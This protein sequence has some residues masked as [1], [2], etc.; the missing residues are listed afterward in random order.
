MS[1]AGWVL[2]SVLLA[3]LGW[4]AATDSVDFPIYHHAGSQVLA[5]DFELYPS[6]VY[7][8]RP[9]GGHGFRY[10]PV[11]ALLFVPFALLPLPLAAGIFYAVKVAAIVA[12]ALLLARHAT[13]N[14]SGGK[15]L[16]LML[17]ATG[18][19][20]LEELRGGNLQLLVIAGVV[21]ATMRAASGA[22][23]VP[24]LI[25]GL[26]IA[27][28]VT[29]AAFVAY[30][31][32]RHGVRHFVAAAAVLSVVL[33]GP[34]MVWGIEQNAHLLTGFA[35][36]SRTSL[37]TPDNARNFSIR[38][39]L[40]KVLPPTMRPSLDGIWAGV[41]GVLALAVFAR[42]RRPWTLPRGQ[43]ELALLLTLMPLLSPHS[44]RIYFTALS[45]A[46]L[47]MGAAVP[48]EVPLWWRVCRPVLWFAG[49]VS[50]LLPLLLSSRSLSLRYMDLFPYTLSAAVFA[51]MLFVALR[52]ALPDRGKATP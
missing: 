36:Y 40:S 33:A 11:W 12:L 30:V 42:L 52:H 28:K 47:L 15:L 43:L 25:F 6:E 5:G 10:A 8:G 31:A 22:I 21:Y 45:A 44:Q 14:T 18:G 48:R 51:A 1:R 38:G 35:N 32:L 3:A 49:V 39:W 50:T 23:A 34:A 9:V 13:A 24:A 17:L 27:A 46:V 29:P 2:A 4:R 37:E 16:G 19:Y 41:V 26:A 7:D 20:L